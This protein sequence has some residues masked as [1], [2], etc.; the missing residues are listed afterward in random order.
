MDENVGNDLEVF[1]PS[2]ASGHFGQ[3]AQ[4]EVWV[5]LDGKEVLR[6][7]SAAFGFSN[8]EFCLGENR[9]HAT[10]DDSLFRGCFIQQTWTQGDQP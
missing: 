2:F 5:N 10:M 4:G 6:A 1:F 7:P 9:A 8:D 3:P